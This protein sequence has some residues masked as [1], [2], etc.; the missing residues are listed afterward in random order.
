M[1]GGCGPRVSVVFC[2]DHRDPDGRVV[3]DWVASVACGRGD[4]DVDVL[5]LAAAGL[6]EV[7]CC[8]VP[9]PPAVRDLAPWLRFAD[10]FVVVAPR[11]L[12][13][14]VARAVQWCAAGWRGKPVAFAGVPP[15]PLVALLAAV[16]VV[17]LDD[18]MR[19]PDRFTA[20]RVLAEFAR[21]P[22]EQRKE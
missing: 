4:L 14:P 16:P 21:I 13:S 2:T 15:A 11:W 8:A 7:D 17:L 10:G 20:D 3:A 22:Y 12:P 9:T 19:F 6:P 18:S 5:D 1:R